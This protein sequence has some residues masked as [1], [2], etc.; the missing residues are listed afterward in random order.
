MFRLEVCR[1]GQGHVDLGYFEERESG[2]A[3]SRLSPRG[4]DETAVFS[5]QSSRG[6]ARSLCKWRNGKG[7]SLQTA[8]T[9]PNSLASRASPYSLEWAYKSAQTSLHR[10]A[11][12]GSI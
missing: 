11:K 5:A 6:R 1:D 9:L 2:G 3:T 12:N 4:L 8:F 10:P 7:N